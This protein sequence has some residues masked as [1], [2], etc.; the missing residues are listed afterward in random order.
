MNKI[1]CKKHLVQYEYIQNRNFEL[2]GMPNN[3][4]N[5]NTLR[6]ADDGMQQ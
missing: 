6:Y 5:N 3:N 1:E 2:E 4:N